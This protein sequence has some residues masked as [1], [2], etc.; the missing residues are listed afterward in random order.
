MTY[1]EEILVPP[2]VFVD[3]L[4]VKSVSTLIFSLP[5]E[6]STN[7]IKCVASVF[8]A[9]TPTS[10]AAPA[11]S[12]PLLI[13]LVFVPSDANTCPLVPKSPS[14]SYNLP[15]ISISLNTALPECVAPEVVP[16]ICVVPVESL[17][18][19]ASIPDNS[20]PSPINLDAVMIPTTLIFCTSRSPNAKISSNNELPS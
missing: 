17:I 10:A 3:G 13:Q 11:V 7:V 12:D 8:T 14:P 1:K 16:C 18:V 20:D 5:D 19:V 15:P 9:V 2:K 4:Y 6:E